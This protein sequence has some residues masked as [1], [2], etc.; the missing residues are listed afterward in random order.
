VSLS[1]LNMPSR[2]FFLSLTSTLL[3][4]PNEIREREREK[5]K[6]KNKKHLGGISKL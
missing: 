6:I 4:T 1:E 3:E 2:Y 5:V